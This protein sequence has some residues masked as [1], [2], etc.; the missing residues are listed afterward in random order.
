MAGDQGKNKRCPENDAGQ[1]HD[2]LIHVVCFFVLFPHGKPGEIIVVRDEF[3]LFHDLRHRQIGG[4]RFQEEQTV[5]L[6][7][8]IS[9]HDYLARFPMGK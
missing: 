5:L 4:P 6:F 7:E 2:D 8:L 3:E 9:Y 1:W